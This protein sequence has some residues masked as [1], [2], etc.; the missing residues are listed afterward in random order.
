MMPMS[1]EADYDAEVTALAIKALQRFFFAGQCLGP[2]FYRRPEQP[3]SPRQ[4]RSAPDLLYA[5]A[6]GINAGIAVWT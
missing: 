6:N 5:S 4:A 2:E 3:E 1:L